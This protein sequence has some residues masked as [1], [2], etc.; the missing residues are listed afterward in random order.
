MFTLSS[1]KCDETKEFFVRYEYIGIDIHPLGP[2]SGKRIVRVYANSQ[3]EALLVA[4]MHLHLVG[5]EFEICDPVFE[6]TSELYKG[7]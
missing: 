4:K 6:A 2:S 7:M 3:E 1:R 5:K